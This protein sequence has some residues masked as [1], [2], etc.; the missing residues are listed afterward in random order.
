MNNN[1]KYEDLVVFL[2]KYFKGQLD[3]EQIIKY[4]RHLPIGL[5]ISY[6]IDYIKLVRRLT[7]E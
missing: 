7:N 4:I 1:E 2:T 6:Y 5:K 3:R